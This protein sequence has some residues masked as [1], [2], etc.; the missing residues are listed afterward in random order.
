MSETPQNSDNSDSSS[1]EHVDPIGL[2]RRKFAA[3]LYANGELTTDEILA[4]RAALGVAEPV[5]QA[6]DIKTPHDPKLAFRLQ[7][8]SG[9]VL[10]DLQQETLKARLI[11]K[12]TPL[13]EVERI[14]EIAEQAQPPVDRP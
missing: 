14:S 13:E 5:A 2:R 10:D 6:A 1:A 3:K 11:N 12:T 4:A 8:Q 9:M 7:P